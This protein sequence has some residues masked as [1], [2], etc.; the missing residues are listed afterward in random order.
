MLFCFRQRS[1]PTLSS[2]GA[3]ITL[4]QLIWLF[5]T[6]RYVLWFMFECFDCSIWESKFIFCEICQ[7]LISRTQKVSICFL[8]VTQLLFP[9]TAIGTELVRFLVFHAEFA[10][11][12]VS[13]CR[14]KSFM[15]LL[16]L[17]FVFGSLF[18]VWYIYGEGVV[19]RR[20]H[21]FK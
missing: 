20:A 2:L 14:K 8:K 15:A 4:S 13:H 19:I 10:D 9:V 21:D 1:M 11:T 17:Y 6:S 3:P 7:R 16:V 18:C 12:E 5:N